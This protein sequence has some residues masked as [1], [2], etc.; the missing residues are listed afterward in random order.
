MAQGDQ[1]LALMLKRFGKDLVW[2]AILTKA[3]RDVDLLE[4]TDGVRMPVQVARLRLVV[5]AGTL[6]NLQSDTAI[7]WDGA[8]YV[9]QTPPVPIEDG[10]FEQFVVVPA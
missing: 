10:A 4:Q 3:V 7:T 2:G 9:A 5:L 6:P 8:A 1:H